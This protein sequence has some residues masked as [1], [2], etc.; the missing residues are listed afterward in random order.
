M[1]KEQ[2]AVHHLLHASLPGGWHVVQKIEKDENATGGNFS[3]GYIVENENK[4]RAFLKALDYSA[5]HNSPNTADVLNEMITAFIYERD[6]L[7]KCD[8]MT[9]VVNAIDGGSYQVKGEFIFPNVDYLIL[10]IADGDI[11]DFLNFSNIF[12]IAWA[13]RSLHH[14]SIGIQQMHQKNIA[15]QDLKPSN[16]LLFNNRKVT[17]IGDVGSASELGVETLHEDDDIAGDPTY[18]PIE[19]KYGYHHSDWRIRRFGCD[20]YLFGNLIVFIFAKVN[21]TAGII[22]YLHRQHR[23][24]FGSDYL[25]VLPYIR[26]AFNKFIVDIEKQIPDTIKTEIIEVVRQLCDPDP[27]LRGHPLEKYIYNDQFLMTRYISLFNKLATEAEYG[28]LGYKK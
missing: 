24:G 20:M 11:R 12:D 26:S 6:L 9:H 17:K 7:K 5:A 27:S 1:G 10:E 8:K 28:I 21:I 4:Q 14:V 3:V 18:A 15:H 2:F 25:T 13:L 22:Y 16:V 23:P 19:Q